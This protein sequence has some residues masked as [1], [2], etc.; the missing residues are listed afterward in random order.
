MTEIKQLLDR[1]RS[2]VNSRNEHGATPLMYASMRNSPQVSMYGQFVAE[3]AT[4]TVGPSCLLLAFNVCLLV[5]RF[6]VSSSGVGQTS[7]LKTRCPTGLLSCSLCIMGKPQ[8][9]KGRCGSCLLPHLD[10]VL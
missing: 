9:I 6:A 4:H 8:L 1:D 3:G 5:F 7:M 10:L 2:I